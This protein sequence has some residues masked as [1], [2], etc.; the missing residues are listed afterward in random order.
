MPAHA[1]DPDFEARARRFSEKVRARYDELGITTMEL[2]RLTGISQ[3]YL[4]LLLNG[5]GGHRDPVTGAYKPPNPTMDVA[6]KLAAALE[7]DLGSLVDP[8][9]ELKPLNR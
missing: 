9:Q 6:W 3:G 7:V 1:H 2:T 8:E 4:K 5:R